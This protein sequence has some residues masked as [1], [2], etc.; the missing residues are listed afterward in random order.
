MLSQEQLQ[1]SLMSAVSL[2]SIMSDATDILDDQG[3][4]LLDTLEG[5]FKRETIRIPHV[6]AEQ[7]PT[8]IVADA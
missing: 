1:Q 7:A 3:H 6:Y 2:K 4:T 8:C 5:N